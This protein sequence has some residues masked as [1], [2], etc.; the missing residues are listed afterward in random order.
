MNHDPRDSG[1]LEQQ[2][3]E[4]YRR[5]STQE[6]SHALDA[7]I[8]AAAQAHLDAQAQTDTSARPRASAREPWLSR[9]HAWLFAGSPRGR[10]SVAFASLAVVGIG[11]TLSVRTYE[12]APSGFDDAV[13]MMAPAAP[14]ASEAV[15]PDA[16]YAADSVPTPAPAQAYAK[17]AEKKR[18]ALHEEVEAAKP[19]QRKSAPVDISGRLADQA[20]PA[21]AA[22]PAA[23]APAPFARKAEKQ[24]LAQH[25]EAQLQRALQQIVRLQRSGSP[26][27][28]QQ[29]LKTLQQLHPDRDLA[30]ELGRLQALDG[31]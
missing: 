22:P 6:P 24:V 14:I 15:D 3:L 9:L 12:R 11:V 16:G 1:D 5:H 7:Q 29:Q 10:W 19:E 31:R 30:A 2:M 28:A 25:D 18:S 4:H 20:Q 21:L 17:Q 26:E 27:L 8:L 13:P 23:S